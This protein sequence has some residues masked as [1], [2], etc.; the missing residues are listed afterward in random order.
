M[1]LES[2][3]RDNSERDEQLAA[4]PSPRAGRSW[5]RRSDQRAPGLHFLPR[6]RAFSKHGA[7]HGKAGAER[8]NA[9]KIKTERGEPAS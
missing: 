6:G 3:M 1:N 8:Q 2:R 5:P 9:S 7:E 4:S